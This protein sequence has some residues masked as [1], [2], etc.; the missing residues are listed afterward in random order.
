MTMLNVV[1]FRIRALTAVVACLR[2]L[3][4]EL[5][6]HFTPARVW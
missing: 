5:D 1:D 3:L 2:T 4:F 6:G